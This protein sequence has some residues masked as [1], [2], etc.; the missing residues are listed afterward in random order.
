MVVLGVLFDKKAIEHA[1]EHDDT[2]YFGEILWRR[3]DQLKLR[4][5]FVAADVVVHERLCAKQGEGDQRG[6]VDGEPHS[7]WLVIL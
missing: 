7:G 6:F 1:Y 3:H 5:V 2:Q 4:L